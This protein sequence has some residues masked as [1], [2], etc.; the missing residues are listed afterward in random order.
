MF[1]PGG[2]VRN[3]LVTSGR[4][5]GVCRRQADRTRKSPK[6]RPEPAYSLYSTD[7]ENQVATLHKGL[8]RCAALLTDILQCENQDAVPKQDRSVKCA[9]P[10]SRPHTPT[11]GKKAIR[12]SLSKSDSAQACLHLLEQTLSSAPSFETTKHQAPSTSKSQTETAEAQLQRQVNILNQQLQDQEATQK[13]L[14]SQVLSLQGQLSAAEKELDQVQKSLQLTQS[15]FQSK[16]EENV[17]LKT[18]LESTKSRL[19]VALQDKFKLEGTVQQKQQ[20]KE[21]LQRIIDSLDS[22]TPT[23]DHQ[24]ARPPG[25]AKEHITQYLLSLEQTRHMQPPSTLQV[26]ETQQRPERDADSV[27]SD[28]S[29]Q[30]ES[31][32]NTRDEAAFRDGLAAL[33]A[34]IASLQNT[35]KMDLIKT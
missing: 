28:W 26:P 1:T 13:L 11:T 22:S 2:T 14:S 35:L 20:E 7:S 29:V 25:P 21:A 3:K 33:D 8:D 12:R 18:E 9:A 24:P 15:R 17:A 34:S 16:E 30:S 6:F 23:P 19:R 4:L 27:I 31:S 32:F 5:T 10:K